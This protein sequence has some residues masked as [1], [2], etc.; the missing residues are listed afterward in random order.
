M[1]IRRN[2]RLDPKKI[3][4]TLKEKTIT[5]EEKETISYGRLYKEEKREKGKAHERE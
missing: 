2:S 1:A 4:K 3:E 5:A